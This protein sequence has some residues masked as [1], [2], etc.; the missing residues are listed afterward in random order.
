MSKQKR[1]KRWAETAL[2]RD[3]PRIDV[4]YE[5][6]T[7]GSVGGRVVGA[8]GE[9]LATDESTFFTGINW[10]VSQIIGIEEATRARGGGM[11]MAVSISDEMPAPWRRRGGHRYRQGVLRFNV[12]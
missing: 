12:R 4:E 2:L 9:I 8:P 11:R 1:P 6:Y 3:R 5:E 7:D 10:L